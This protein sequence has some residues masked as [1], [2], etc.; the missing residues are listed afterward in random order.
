MGSYWLAKERQLLKAEM[1]G[2]FG[3]VDTV[4]VDLDYRLGSTRLSA[5]HTR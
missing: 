4:T 1:K 5:Q 2:L 3:N